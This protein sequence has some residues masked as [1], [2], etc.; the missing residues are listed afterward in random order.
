MIVDIL[1]I[2]LNITIPVIN[3]LIIYKL[4]ERFEFK[5][6]FIYSLLLTVFGIIFKIPLI[7]GFSIFNLFTMND[8]LIFGA[9]VLGCNLIE[10]GIYYFIYTKTSSFFGFWLSCQLALVALYFFS[11]FL[12]TGVFN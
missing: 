6:G 5:G 7:G 2:I 1:E 9:I 3:L 11:E 12:L 8:Y 4:F 10:C